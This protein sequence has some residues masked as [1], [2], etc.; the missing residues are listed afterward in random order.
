MAEELA[1]GPLR[2]VPLALLHGRMDPFEKERIVDAFR[3]GDVRVLVTTTVVEVGVDVRE[4]T[5]M[6]VEGADRFGLAQLHQLRGR[7]GRNRE[8]GLC[9]LVARTGK[10]AER[11]KILEAT[12]S[13]FDIAEAD[14]RLR[15]PGDLIGLRQS[16]RP[17]FALSASSS[18]SSTLAAARAE[19]F[20]LVERPDFLD[21][22]TFT[23]LRDEVRRHW[24]R[25]L[26]LH[27]G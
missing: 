26:H 8:K 6:V 16:G 18:F 23:P 2:G 27:A 12:R 24:G 4:A 17:V 5:C 11:L 7:I 15:G 20:A 9:L 3:R 22:P 14:L 10:S 13:G 21:D 19:A 25:S 1:S